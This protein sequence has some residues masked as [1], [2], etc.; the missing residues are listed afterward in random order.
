M[1]YEPIN[2]LEVLA[3]LLRRLNEMLEDE[4][5]ALTREEIT[6]F[7]QLQAEKEV[8][9][10]RITAIP[11]DELAKE[12]GALE[13]PPPKASFDKLQ[14]AWRDMLVLGRA[15]ADLQKRNEVLINKKLAVVRDALKALEL[16]I[17]YD[18]SEFY[19]PKGRLTQ[20]L[21]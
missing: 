16:S 15:G 13:S 20:K 14:L 17:Q 7:E 11:I 1:E 4:Y 3:G 2:R 18:G 21:P 9:L 10:A 12:L 6:R 19:D 8:L 5:A